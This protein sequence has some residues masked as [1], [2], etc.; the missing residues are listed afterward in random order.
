M[1]NIIDPK[2]EFDHKNINLENPTPIQG[3][4][5]FTKLNFSE[6]KLPLYLQLPKCK[7][8]QGI[9]KN[10][11]TKKCYLDL[12]FSSN[13]IE[14]ITWFEN[15]E[16]RCRE[17]IFEKKDNWFQSEMDLDDIES[18]F[19]SC[20]KSYRSGKNIIIRCYIP[21]TK[22][23]K[24]N[25]CLI[26]DENENVL[27]IEDVK[28]NLDIIPL[29]LIDGI[30]FS[31]KSFQIEINVPQIMVM[32][33]P[34]E[35][36]TDFLINKKKQI[37]ESEIDLEKINTE[38]DNKNFNEEN[39]VDNDIKS[40]IINENLQINKN[41]KEVFQ[42]NSSLENIK[43]KEDLNFLEDSSEI[44]NK[45]LKQIENDLLLEEKEK[46]KEDED[47]KTEDI[48]DNILELKEFKLDLDEDFENDND[49]EITLKK[50]IDVYKEIYKS[51]R[52]RAKRMRQAAMDAYL[53]AKNIKN[54]YMLDDINSEDENSNFE[55]IEELQE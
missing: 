18:H 8:K 14:L 46:N 45:N 3:G 44:E 30:K 2:D 9:I 40:E 37:K 23:I 43:E 27:D 48:S 32:K 28:E 1:E 33:I 49:N 5:F 55:D 17:L 41:D 16:N 38:K 39:K 47:L 31:S 25:Y 51:A 52:D 20:M 4:S 42:E 26:Y 35:I 10:T 34:E 12:L 36:K 50:P 21:N 13:D 19:N 53:E 54:K 29:I 7:T 6:K 15:L 24:K 22:F 11:S